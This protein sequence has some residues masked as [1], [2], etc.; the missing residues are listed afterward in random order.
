MALFHER[1]REHYTQDSRR[2]S[3]I[4]KGVRNPF[5]Q[6]SDFG[7]LLVAESVATRSSFCLRRS[8]HLKHHHIQIAHLLVL[9]PFFFYLFERLNSY[10]FILI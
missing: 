6:S 3:G 10:K 5:I 2:W 8:S 7:C 9:T 1:D 4:D